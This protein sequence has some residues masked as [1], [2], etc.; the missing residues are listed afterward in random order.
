LVLVAV[1]HAPQ[2]CSR[3]DGQVWKQLEQL[4]VKRQQWAGELLGQHNEFGVITGAAMLSRQ[5]QSFGTVDGDGLGQQGLL[6]VAQIVQG[7]VEIQAAGA[8]K[9]QMNMPECAD[10]KR[11][12]PAIGLR[13]PQSLNSQGVLCGQEQLNQHIGIDDNAQGGLPSA[14][15]KGWRSG[16]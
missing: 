12:K 8:K 3:S 14:P 13:C 15:V 9:L 1:P 6:R 10:P 16:G 5:S 4:L 7:R 11:W 2:L